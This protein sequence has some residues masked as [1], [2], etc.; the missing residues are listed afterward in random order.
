[1]VQSPPWKTKLINFFHSIIN[2]IVIFFKTIYDPKAAD[3]YIKKREKGTKGGFSI[4]G[5]SGNGGGGG[6]GPPRPPTRRIAGLSDL[7]D[8]GGNCAAG[9]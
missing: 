2:F 1:M 3:D 4:T 9:A 7:R 8:A 5:G 6:G